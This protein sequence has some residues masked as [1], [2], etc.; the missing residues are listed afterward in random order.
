MEN[1]Q[2][3][4]FKVTHSNLFLAIIIKSNF[5]KDG[6]EFFTPNEF[7][8]QLGYM[9]RP[10]GYEI[11]PHIHNKI[12][13]QVNLT[14]EVLFIKKGKLKVNFYDSDFKFIKFEV[15]EKGDVILLANG[16]HG[17]EILEE[18]EIIEVK[19]GPFLGDTD[20]TRF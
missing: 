7:S 1:S 18:A 13:R 8:Q 16:G 10:K 11:K 12:S 19:Q 6:I 14:Q 4:V 5:K 17:F 15:L 20:K 9:K 2:K 3:S